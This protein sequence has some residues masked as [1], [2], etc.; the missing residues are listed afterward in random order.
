MGN[1]FLGFPVPRAKI[2]EMIEGSA[3]PLK[4]IPNH[5]PPGSDP[6]ALPADISS[7]QLIKWDG[8]KFIGVDKPTAG[9]ASQYD[10]PNFFFT[11]RFPTLDTFVSYTDGTGTVTLYEDHLVIYTGTTQNSLAEIYKE[12]AYPFPSL[13]W[14]KARKFKTKVKFRVDTNNLGEIWVCLGRW[15]YNPLIAFKLK[16]GVLK[17]FCRTVSGEAEV[18]LETLGAGAF[19]ETR[20][21]EMVFTPGSKAE[22]YVDG[23]KQGEITT[24]LPSGTD[25]ANSPMNLVVMNL[26]DAK[27]VILYISQFSMYQA[28]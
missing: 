2:A 17:G 23:D 15:D 4:H 14:D 5:L 21:L 1:M 18:D 11:T 25:T 16:D 13:T 3:P 12:I 9:L 10:D 7:G 27:Q 6:L 26:T 19:E 8:S 28:E 20:D 24:Y 22:F